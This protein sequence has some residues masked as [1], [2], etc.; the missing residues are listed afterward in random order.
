MIE[1][2]GLAVV[3]G[4]TDSHIHPFWGTRLTRGVDLRDA[5]TLEEIR[6][7]LA[8]ERERCGPGE[9]VLGHSAHYE[10]FHDTGLRAVEIVPD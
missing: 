9:W 5:G 8:A 2:A 10:P 7:R 1:G 6:A 3:P 4:L